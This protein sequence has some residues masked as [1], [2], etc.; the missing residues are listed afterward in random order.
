MGSGISY[1]PRSYSDRGADAAV[2]TT[3][4]AWAELVPRVRRFALSLTGN[5]CDADDLVQ[6]TVERALSRGIPPEAEPRRWLFRVCRNLWIDEV[7]GRAVRHRHLEHPAGV[8][9]EGLGDPSGNVD[10]RALEEALAAMQTLS[11]EHREVLSL[12]AIE[13]C[14]YREAAAVLEVPVGTI[15]S[16]LARARATLA[17]RL[18]AG[19]AGQER[20]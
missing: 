18:G 15:M 20:G 16:R 4:H 13:G 2:S 9:G 17:S 3:E 19:D 10:R 8:D 7:R 12:V 6:S 14:S 5:A 1:P 11:S